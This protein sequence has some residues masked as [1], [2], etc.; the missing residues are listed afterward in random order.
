MARRSGGRTGL[1]HVVRLLSIATKAIAEGDY[2]Q[3]IPITSKDEIGQ[4]AVSF[5]AMARSLSESVDNLQR[6]IMVRERAEDNLAE[7]V[8]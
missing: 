5:N 1:Q 7:L 2:S 6:E 3:K 4:L 8:D